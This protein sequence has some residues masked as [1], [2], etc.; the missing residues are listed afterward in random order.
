[1]TGYSSKVREAATKYGVTYT[2]NVGAG[3]NTVISTATVGV[4]ASGSSE[5]STST[6]G[7]AARVTAGAVVLVAGALVLGDWF[8][9]FLA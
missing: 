8:V 5:A 1:M 4:T 3:T 2:A 6:G 9:V 7:A